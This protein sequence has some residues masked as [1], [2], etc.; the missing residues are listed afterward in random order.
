M[1]K[2]NL[3]KNEI[4]YHFETYLFYK[5][6]INKYNIF[7]NIGEYFDNQYFN[8]PEFLKLLDFEDK[9]LENL[10]I[11]DSNNNIDI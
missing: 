1:Q 4:N 5:S 8:N 9:Y 6:I 10:K 11:D 7:K 3:N 2:N